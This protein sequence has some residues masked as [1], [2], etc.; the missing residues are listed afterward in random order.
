MSS[1]G[2][3]ESQENVVKDLLRSSSDITA[4]FNGSQPGSPPQESSLP[5]DPP[6]TTN[7]N[8][9]NGNDEEATTPK[10]PTPK[11]KR[12]SEGTVKELDKDAQK[13]RQRTGYSPKCVPKSV[14]GMDSKQTLR[15][16]FFYLKSPTKV[17]KI[18]THSPISRVS[19]LTFD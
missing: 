18:L 12:S 10:T 14:N 19:A 15:Y 9:D 3:T 11:G 5:I 17:V 6:L 7:N 2:L 1:F 16:L 4:Q 8:P 13:K